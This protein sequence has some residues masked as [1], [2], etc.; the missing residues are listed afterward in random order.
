MAYTEPEAKPTTMYPRYCLTDSPPLRHLRRV[1]QPGSHSPHGVQPG[2]IPVRSTV[3]AVRPRT[4]WHS[5]RWYSRKPSTIHTWD[6]VPAGLSAS[7]LPGDSGTIQGPSTA[8][9][10]ISMEAL[11]RTVMSAAVAAT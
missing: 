3:R 5:R 2:G 8:S 10:V 7:V 9:F 1:L 6:A 4:A 11:T